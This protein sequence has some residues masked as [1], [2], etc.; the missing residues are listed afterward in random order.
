MAELSELTSAQMELVRALRRRPGASV[1]EAAEELRLAPNTVSTLVHRLVASGVVERRAD[2]GD[3]RVARL[4][5][6]AG[7]AQEVGEWRGRRS[8]AVADALGRLAPSDCHALVTALGPLSRL[9]DALWGDG[10]AR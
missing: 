1:A 2:P 9:A 10:D 7:I 4:T 8:D 3:R 6:S 5:L